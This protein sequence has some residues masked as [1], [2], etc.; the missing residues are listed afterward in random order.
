MSNET[1]K[2]DDREPTPDGAARP[3]TPEQAFQL[4]APWWA[5]QNKRSAVRYAI[6]SLSKLGLIL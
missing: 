5:K 6:S 1:A 4:S 3:M 2:R